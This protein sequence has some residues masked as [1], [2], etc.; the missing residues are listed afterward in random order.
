ML[1]GHSKKVGG[2]LIVTLAVLVVLAFPLVFSGYIQQFVIM[3]LLYTYLGSAWNILGGYAGQFSFGH[4]AFFGIGAY[5]STMLFYYGGVSPWIGMWVGV[6]LAA[7]LGVFEG[8]ISFKYGLRGIYFAMVTLAFAEVLRLLMTNW[9]LAGGSEGLSVPLRG[10]APLLF[11]FQTKIPYYYI[12]LVMVSA[13]MYFIRWM[14][15]SRLGLYLVAIRDDQDAAE[16]LG[17]DTMKYKLIAI[18]ISSSLTALAGTFYVQIFMFIDPSIGFSSIMSIDILLRPVIGGEGTL[19]GALLGA[20]VMGG[21][22]EITRSLLGGYSGAHLATY[23][24]ILIVIVLFIPEGIIP[25][26]NR[27]L[28]HSYRK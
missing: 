17:I 18:A 24:I 5:A 8:Y 7:M 4:S 16:A 19:W 28:K 1:N 12:I 22:S 23:G 20:I 6:L 10:S 9:P 21:A 11:Q 3:I 27:F 13:T 14:E 25:W 26:F 2:A 15:K